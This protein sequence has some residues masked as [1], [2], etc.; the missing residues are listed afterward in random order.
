MGRAR[1]N[2]LHLVLT[3]CKIQP[4]SLKLF[5]CL[6]SVPLCCSGGELL[7]V[8]ADGNMPYD[9]CEDEETL[10]FIENEMAKRG[11]QII[12]ASYDTWWCISLTDDRSCTRGMIHTKFHLINPGC[13]RPSIES[14]PKTPFVSFLSVTGASGCWTQDLT[15]WGSIPEAPVK[16]KSLG[17]ALNPH[18][19]WSP[20]SNGYLVHRFKVGSIVAAVSRYPRQGKGKVWWI[21]H[22][23]LDIKQIA[24]YL[25]Y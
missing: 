24:L 22:R 4:S 8:N 14:W 6:I 25:S 16:C 10:D 18:C 9:I 1:E 20:S 2:V 7:A 23:D 11:K 12:S 5:P 13:P 21:L 3:C 19:L 15:I 17:Q